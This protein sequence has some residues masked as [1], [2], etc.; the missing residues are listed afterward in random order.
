MTAGCATGHAWVVA[1]GTCA[2]CA[3]PV[4]ASG[5]LDDTSAPG[6]L[7]P[8]FADPATSAT[9]RIDGGPHAPLYALGTC[10]ACSTTVEAAATDDGLT[11]WFE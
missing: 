7:A 1:G 10:T 5:A 8:P 6:W 3:L 4:Q 11:A 2:G 9:C